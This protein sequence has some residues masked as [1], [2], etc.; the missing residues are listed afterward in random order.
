MCEIN[1]TS[2]T[3]VNMGATLADL[4]EAAAKLDIHITTEDI[5][6]EKELEHALAHVPA[7]ADALWMTCSHLL[8]SNSDKIAG[9]ALSR[10][11]PAASS[12]QSPNRKGMLVSYGE[13]DFVLGE[14]VGRLAHHILRG[15]PP[16]SLPVETADFFLRIDLKVA[17]ALGIS[18]PNNI[19]QQAHYIDH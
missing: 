15:T 13:S 7:D 9:A 6:N 1:D 18:V 17:Q 19:L 10:K 2:A 12:T 3:E 4:R 14:Q 16:S 8:F 11:I 5:S